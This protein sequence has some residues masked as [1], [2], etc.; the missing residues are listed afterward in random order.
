MSDAAPAPEPRTGPEAFELEE[1]EYQLPPAPKTLAFATWRQPR[2]FW[3]LTLEQAD[4]PAGPEFRV[5]K[6]YEHDLVPIPEGDTI[7]SRGP[8]LGAAVR[9]F[10]AW[11]EDLNAPPPPSGPDDGWVDPAEVRTLRRYERGALDELLSP[12]THPEPAGEPASAPAPPPAPVGALPV[13][14]TP[15][16]AGPGMDA[17]HEAAG[18]AAAAPSPAVA[19]VDVLAEYRAVVRDVVALIESERAAR[20]WAE[21]TGRIGRVESVVEA[22][23]ES[24]EASEQALGEVERLVRAR[25]SDPERLLER[26]AE[27]DPAEVR[28]FA[29]LL[30]SEPMALAAIE[31]RWSHGPAGPDAAVR[32]G[33]PEPQL[34]P[35]RARGLQ[36][37]MGRLD[38]EA[39]QRQARVAAVALETWADARQRGDQTRQWAAG[40]LFLSPRTPLDR[41]IEVGEARAAELRE[42]YREV[43]ELGEQRSPAPSRAHIERR[44]AGMDPHAAE[45]IRSTFSE[46]L[47][48]ALGQAAP[49]R[50]REA[51]SLSR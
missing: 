35:V 16:P 32:A 25:F 29:G 5:V 3:A 31:P 10:D 27:M 40:E 13:H 50:S 45:H 22:V 12:E 15:S 36:G 20:E 28:R 23:R 2:A 19:G 34:I 21:A 1:A 51:P 18:G 9:E 24:R 48:P 33:A 47:S 37:L 44:L 39:T 46:F 17:G 6:T 49:V 38:I 14:A 8:D 11:F 42:S 30:R 43:I 4:T 26:L 41:V 7:V